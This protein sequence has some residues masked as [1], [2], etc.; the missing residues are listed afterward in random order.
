MQYRQAIAKPI[1]DHRPSVA[2]T[3]AETVATTMAKTMVGVALRRETMAIAAC[4]RSRS[5]RPN[6]STP[7]THLHA[8]AA[9][10][11]CSRTRSAAPSK[12]KSQKND[13]PS[14]TRRF[15]ST[16]RPV[17]TYGTL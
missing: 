8:S 4:R 5:G 6:G 15:V 10:T 17:V 16:R 2:K 3:M 9:A 14:G 7:R 11:A 12:K 1:A 13:F